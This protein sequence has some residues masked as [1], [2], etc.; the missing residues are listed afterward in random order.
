MW[1]TEELLKLPEGGETYGNG[2][3][4]AEA[5]RQGVAAAGAAAAT[6]TEWRRVTK[7]RHSN[8]D[9]EEC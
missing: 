1:E 9:T 2:A 5:G 7:M 3:N 6:A 4:G 8:Q